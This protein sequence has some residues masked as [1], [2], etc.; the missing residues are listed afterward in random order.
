[1]AIVDIEYFDGINLVIDGGS[2]DNVDVG[3]IYEGEVT[4]VFDGENEDAVIFFGEHLW[5]AWED[6]EDGWYYRQC[7]CC[8]AWDEIEA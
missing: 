3:P 6:G 5:G 8:G 7:V 4:I 2:F 1:M